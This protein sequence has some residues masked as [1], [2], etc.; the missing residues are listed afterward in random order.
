MDELEE[1][2]KKRLEL[3][4]VR[5]KRV[6]LELELEA[7]RRDAEAAQTRLKELGGKGGDDWAA[8]RVSSGNQVYVCYRFT[9]CGRSREN[10][11]R[12]ATRKHTV[13]H[14]FLHGCTGPP[15][16]PDNGFTDTR[17]HTSSHPRVHEHMRA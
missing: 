11:H 5:Q 3:E 2:A 15:V 6:A 7:R 17:M 1:R 8:E 9:L 4:E 16:H 12:I 10:S 14:F 13:T